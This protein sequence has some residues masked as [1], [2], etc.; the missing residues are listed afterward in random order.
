MIIEATIIEAF[1]LNDTLTFLAKTDGNEKT[2][3]HFK[4]GTPEFIQILL[5]MGITK[6]EEFHCEIFQNKL[7][8]LLKNENIRKII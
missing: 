8:Y 5:K 7:C 3:F 6:V 2:H 1:I 4:R